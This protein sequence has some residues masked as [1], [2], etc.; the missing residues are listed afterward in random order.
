MSPD[1]PFVRRSVISFWL[2]CWLVAVPAT[3]VGA[4]TGPTVAQLISICERGIAAGD[5]GVDA[6]MCEWYAVPCDCSAKRPDTTERWCRSDSE[7]IEAALPRVLRALKAYPRPSAAVEDVV[8]G[9]MARLYP[10]ANDE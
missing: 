10:C 8:P 2:V 7:P 1:A 4:A 5:V 3:P 9:V 6:A